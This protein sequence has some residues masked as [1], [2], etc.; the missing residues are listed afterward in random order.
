MTFAPWVALSQLARKVLKRETKA[1]FARVSSDQQL[2][3]SAIHKAKLDLVEAST[4]SNA[5]FRRPKSIIAT[6]R[7]VDEVAMRLIHLLSLP[8]IAAVA[9]YL[10]AFQQNRL[11]SAAFVGELLCKSTHVFYCV[12][13]LPQI[14]INYNAKSGSL[15]PVTYNLISLSGPMLAAIFPYI[16]GVSE[17]RD[18]QVRGFPQELCHIVIVLQ[19]IVYYQ[20]TKTD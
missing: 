19:R 11:W 20:K 4:S 17:V 18:K 7:R 5:Y 3:L 1:D 2:A 12:A 14:I 6:R 10:F 9:L 8:V 16:M 13:W 15:T